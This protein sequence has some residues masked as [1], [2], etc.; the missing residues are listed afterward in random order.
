MGKIENQTNLFVQ[1]VAV[2]TLRTKQGDMAFE[3]GF[4]SLCR[5]QVN[6]CLSD[7]AFQGQ[8]GH[9]PA[10]TLNGVIAEIDHGADTQKCR[11]GAPGIPEE[12]T[13]VSHD[14]K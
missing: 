2:Q 14:L 3:Q 5:L 8:Q 4:F 9:D 12:I 6:L 1:H 11:D 10:L 13:Q 7:L